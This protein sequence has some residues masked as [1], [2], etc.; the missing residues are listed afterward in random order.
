MPMRIVM[1]TFELKKW[2]CLPILVLLHFHNAR[3]KSIFYPVQVCTQLPLSKIPLEVH[4]NCSGPGLIIHCLP[5]TID[6]LGLCCFNWTWISPG[7]C[8]YYNTYRGNMDE[9]NCSQKGLCPKQ[10]YKS[11]GSL[12]YTGCYQKE[13]DITDSTT[14][15]MFT[16]IET[17]TDATESHDI[18]CPNQA[19]RSSSNDG[20]VA[21]IV[22]TGLLAVLSIVF[23]VVICCV[24]N[25]RQRISDL[26]SR[27]GPSERQSPAGGVLLQSL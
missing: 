3:G 13:F 8:P 10:Q 18:T 20:Y 15:E 1:C 17:N 21:G 24:P 6:S 14:T 23:A 25:I 7:K 19:T 4:E 22:V 16:T 26:L 27:T 11:P 9:K 2:I 12:K 5:N